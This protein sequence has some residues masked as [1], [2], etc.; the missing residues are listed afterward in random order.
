MPQLRVRQQQFT[1]SV[2]RGRHRLTGCVEGYCR[3]IYRSCWD[4]N[5]LVERD[6]SGIAEIAPVKAVEQI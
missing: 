4:A 6:G 2:S 3:R 5:I 1:L